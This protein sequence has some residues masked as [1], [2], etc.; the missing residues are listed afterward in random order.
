MQPQINRF[1]TCV[2]KDIEENRLH[3][4]IQGKIKSL[5]RSCN[6]KSRQNKKRIINTLTI[7]IKCYDRCLE[8]Q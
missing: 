5:S 2:A 8:N 6:K 1:K 3:S 7:M 4:M